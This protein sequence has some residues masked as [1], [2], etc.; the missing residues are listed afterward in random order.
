MEVGLASGGKAACLVLENH[1]CVRPES[2]HGLCELTNL[3]CWRSLTREGKAPADGQ[4]HA[5]GVP[6]VLAGHPE[7]GADI[8]EV[9][10]RI[11]TYR[12]LIVH[13]PRALY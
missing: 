8:A 13:F 5:R 3:L 1:A 7:D 11:V 2:H 4:L 6:R 12:I 9:G 10:G